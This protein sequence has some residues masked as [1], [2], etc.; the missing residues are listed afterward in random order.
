MSGQQTQQ[1]ITAPS[2]D[3]LQNI[4]NELIAAL[5]VVVAA[6]PAAYA[7]VSQL[8]EAFQQAASSQVPANTQATFTQHLNNARQHAQALAS[9]HQAQQVAGQQQPQQPA[10]SQPQPQQ[11]FAQT[12]V[13][14]PNPPQHAQQAPATSGQAAAPQQHQ[15]PGLPGGNQSR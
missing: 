9:Q 10:Q 12:Q 4:G 8:I 2:A 7:I 6:T 3:Q 11:N 1:G 5:K 15:H 13:P 14:Q